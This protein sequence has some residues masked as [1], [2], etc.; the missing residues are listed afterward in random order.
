M[1]KTNETDNRTYVTP[2]VDEILI[3]SGN[4]I[5]TSPGGGGTGET[6]SEDG[7]A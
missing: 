1:K 3:K 2:E 5:M 6:G 4:V 7:D